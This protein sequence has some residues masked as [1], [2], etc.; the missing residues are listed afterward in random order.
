LR[1]NVNGDRQLIVTPQM[2]W[3]DF[4]EAAKIDRCNI[5]EIGRKK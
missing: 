5:R 2:Q 1:Q 3:E 4:S